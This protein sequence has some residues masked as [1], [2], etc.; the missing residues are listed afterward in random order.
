MNTNLNLNLK[1]PGLLTAET[2]AAS[3]TNEAGTSFTFRV[4]KKPDVNELHCIRISGDDT[5]SEGK[6]IKIY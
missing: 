3:G 4:E 6:A 5:A 2:F 1:D